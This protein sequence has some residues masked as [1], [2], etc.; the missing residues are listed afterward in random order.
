MFC[1]NDLKLSKDG[2][3]AIMF[4]TIFYMIKDGFKRDSFTYIHFDPNNIL[5]IKP[6]VLKGGLSMILEGL[7]PMAL[8]G[9]F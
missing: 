4:S 3:D 6:M 7:L 9:V 8:N 1:L 2:A 5:S